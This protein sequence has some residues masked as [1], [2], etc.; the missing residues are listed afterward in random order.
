[1]GSIIRKLC[2]SQIT[3]FNLKFIKSFKIIKIIILIMHLILCLVLDEIE[4]KIMIENQVE[5]NPDNAP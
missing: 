5:S 3:K 1:M 2:K 4:T